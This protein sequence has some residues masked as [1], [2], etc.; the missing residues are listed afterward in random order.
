MELLIAKV[1]NT[2][3]RTAS[4]PWHQPQVP[5]SERRLRLF[6][7]AASPQP[8]GAIGVNHHPQLGVRAYDDFPE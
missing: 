7:A 1:Y 6:A 5:F 4:F 8:A 2:L 3:T